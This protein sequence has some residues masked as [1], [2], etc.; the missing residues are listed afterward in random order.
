MS[1]Q[2][3]GQEGG[4]I[5]IGVVVGLILWAVIIGGCVW[6]KAHVF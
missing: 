1:E 3:Q 6:I 4:G 2:E 5:V